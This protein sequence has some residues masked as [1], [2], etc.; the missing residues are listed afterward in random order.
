MIEKSCR[1]N[2]KSEKCFEG[3]GNADKYKIYLR[4]ENIVLLKI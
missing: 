4:L 1:T 2:K 3:D